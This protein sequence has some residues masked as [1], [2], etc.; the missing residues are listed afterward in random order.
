MTITVS[1]T[2]DNEAAAAAWLSGKP[3]SGGSTGSASSGKAADKPAAPKHSREEMQAIMNKL[4]EATD[5]DTC[6]AVMADACGAP[7]KM[8]EAKEDKF[9]AIYALAEKK[10]AEKADEV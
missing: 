1:K 6:R 8:S 7:T 2:F 3:A 10:L 5:A 4:K 9:D